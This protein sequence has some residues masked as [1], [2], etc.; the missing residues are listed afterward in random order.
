M[1]RA[2]FLVLSIVFAVLLGL[3]SARAYQRPW[4]LER[5]S[6]ADDGSESQ[7]W[8]P[9]SSVSAD[10]RYVAFNSTASNLVP[11]DTNNQEDLFVRDRKNGRTIRVNVASDGTEANGQSFAPNISANGRF[12]A[13]VS[14]ASNLVPGAS[15]IHVYVH[16][17][18]TRT[19]EVADVNGDEVIGNGYA[20]SPAISEDGRFVA[21]ESTA[22]NLVSNDTNGTASATTDVFVRDR[23]AGTT[24]RVSV[25]TDGRESDGNSKYP[26]ISADGRF[27]AFQSEATTLVV[28]DLNA[29][30]DPL[31]RTDVFVHDRQNHTTELASVTSD[32]MQGAGMGGFPQLS[33]DGRYVAFIGTMS[34]LV[35]N[36]GNR[37][38]DVFVRDRQLGITERVSV[39]SSGAEGNNSSLAPSISADGRF[40]VFGSDATNLVAGDANG[41]HD[42]FIHDRSTGS[43]ERLSVTSA[44]TEVPGQAITPKITPDGRHVAFG[45]FGPLLPEDGNSNFDVYLV[46]RGP[47]LGVAQLSASREG[48][49]VHV[50]GS[51]TLDGAVVSSQAD[52]SGA[53]EAAAGLDLVGASVSYRPEAGDL[54]VE[55][56]VASMPG[57]RGA[58]WTQ[59][60]AGGIGPTFQLTFDFGGA[61]WIVK[62]TRV[63]T[64]AAGTGVAEHRFFLDRC[65]GGQCV[66]LGDLQGSVGTT[67]ESAVATVPLSLLTGNN[68]GLREIE[69]TVFL[70]G[71][72]GDLVVLPA[73]SPLSSEVAVGLAPPGQQ[74][75]SFE[76]T[77]L[78]DGRF[79]ATLPVGGMGEQ[80]VV[81]RVC[82]AGD[83]TFDR[84]PVSG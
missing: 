37:V 15:G 63:S 82:R 36:D 57:A 21:F 2:A 61:G 77:E 39:S 67:A 13:F 48:D 1:R 80:E 3:T 22:S 83:C 42:S 9:Y 53:P 27:V 14:F 84:V 10:G 75:E 65:Q 46:D 74:P 54:L 38:M 66:R 55:W 20:F 62:G 60:G 33:A 41:T 34:N 32:E 19:T 8:S 4:G 28:P 43:T 56:R 81:V 23:V 6:L 70:E 35:P 71:L 51:A 5:V 26:S 58:V 7:G 64:N 69:A 49:V 17:L 11:G 29:A 16:D 59:P 30:Q 25:S 44:G 76:T 79:A 72:S 31:F 24:E 12:A 52:P 73:T 50:T 18:K 45:S 47:S 68:D 78:S 40:V